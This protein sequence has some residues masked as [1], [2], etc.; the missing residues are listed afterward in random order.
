MFPAY[1]E[2]A[3]A[4]REDGECD[5]ESNYSSFDAQRILEAR[6]LKEKRAKEEKIRERRKNEAAIRYIYSDD[7]DDDVQIHV[8]SPALHFS[9][10]S[11]PKV[12]LPTSKKKKKKSKKSKR[13]K[14]KQKRVKRTR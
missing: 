11:V 8:E 12:D 5:D 9:P 6:A 4:E 7:D 13:R 2:P 1:A 10:I 3:T 14:Q